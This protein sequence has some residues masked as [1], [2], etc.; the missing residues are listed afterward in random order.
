VKY[1]GIAVAAVLGIGLPLYVHTQLESSEPARDSVVAVAPAELRLTF[2]E[3]V[4]P[5]LSE[6]RLAVDGT[7]EQV[8]QDVRQ[9]AAPVELIASVDGGVPAGVWTVKW[10]VAGAD[11]HPVSGSYAF[12]VEAARPLLVEAPPQEAASQAIPVEEEEPITVSSPAFVAA[13]WITFVAML[14]VIGVV[15]FRYLVLHPARMRAPVLAGAMDTAAVGAARLGRGAAMFLSLA[16]G[17]RLLLQLETMGG[18]DLA[19]LRDLLFASTWGIAWFL[20]LAMALLALLGFHLV[21]VTRAGGWAVAAVAAVGI[22]L[23]GSL[24]S[25]AAASDLATLGV[26]ADALH[27]LAVSGWL[28]TLLVM[29]GVGIPAVLREDP[30]SGKFSAA[31]ALVSS[32][33][34]RALV[35]AAVAAMTGAVGAL[36]HVPTIA[37]LWQTSYGQ[38]LLVKLALVAAAAGLGAWNWRRMKPRL[39]EGEPPERLRRTAAAEL[40]VGALVLLATAILVALPTP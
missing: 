4:D 33:S 26:T 15:A 17:V 3:R 35:M 25:H 36:L 40:L 31:S 20:Q 27:T 5:D 2:N 21:V 34:P 13:R 8:L 9:G 11:G 22:A 12:R 16:A 39:A 10:R 32:F 14:T 38:A 1:W 19:L 18:A 23:G 37:S 30:R 6:I 29:V 7:G 24:A 28:G